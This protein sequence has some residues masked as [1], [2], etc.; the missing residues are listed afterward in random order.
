[1]GIANRVVPTGTSR[2]AAETLAL[3]L[4]NF[5]QVC[6]RGDRLSAYEQFD[7]T[8][9]EAL[10]NEFKHGLNSLKTEAAAGAQRFAGGAGRHGSYQVE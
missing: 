3:E 4:A 5:P 2:Q 8:L 6:L 7:L 1:M 10:A 9:D